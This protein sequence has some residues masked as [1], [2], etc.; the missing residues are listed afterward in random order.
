MVQQLRPPGIILEDLSLIPNAY[1]AA[2]VGNSRSGGS[3]ALFW[4][5]WKPGTHVMH[6]YTCWEITHTQKE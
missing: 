3:N 6:S 1:M 4:P 2:H 5:P